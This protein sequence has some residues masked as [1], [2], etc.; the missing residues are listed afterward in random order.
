MCSRKGKGECVGICE[1]SPSAGSRDR[2]RCHNATFTAATEH[3][4]AA[5]H[6]G[7][8]RHRRKRGSLDIDAALTYLEELKRRPS[9]PTSKEMIDQYTKIL[10]SSNTP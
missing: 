1:W 5:A 9:F 7:S 2:S 8:T 6:S 4:E 3:R 10:F